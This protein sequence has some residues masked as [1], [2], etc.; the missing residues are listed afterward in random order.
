MYINL[1]KIE[2]EVKHN[3]LIDPNIYYHQLRRNCLSY[4]LIDLKGKEFF[5]KFSIHLL[6]DRN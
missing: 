1:F 4:L 3:G 6:K 5:T 2:I